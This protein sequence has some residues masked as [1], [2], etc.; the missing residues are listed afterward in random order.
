[1]S[2]NAKKGG[3]KSS[4]SVGPAAADRIDTPEALDVAAVLEAAQK[5]ALERD[6]RRRH[7][8][9]CPAQREEECSCPA[10]LHSMP[11]PKEVAEVSGVKIVRVDDGKTIERTFADPQGNGRVVKRD[12]FLEPRWICTVCGG[13]YRVPHLLGHACDPAFLLWKDRRPPA[14]AQITAEQ[15]YSGALRLAIW[16]DATG[17]NHLIEMIVLDGKVIY[18]RERSTDGDY[19]V[20]EG[21]LS[22]AVVEEFSA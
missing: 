10:N 11:P 6:K 3:Q 15:R 19:L 9:E 18:E 17:M 22:D 12:V 1:M 8:P 20:I 4:P 13:S 2:D 14:N 5:L 7:M 16:R 21:A